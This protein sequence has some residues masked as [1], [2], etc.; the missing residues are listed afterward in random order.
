M[1]VNK[2]ELAGQ[3]GTGKMSRIA[4]E[5]AEALHYFWLKTEDEQVAL[6]KRRLESIRTYCGLEIDRML[7]DET[8]YE[9]YGPDRRE[10]I[11]TM[12]TLSNDDARDI[13]DDMVEGR[14]L[15]AVSDRVVKTI[16]E[17]ADD[18]QVNNLPIHGEY[19]DDASADCLWL[20][21]LG[22]MKH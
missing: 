13:R 21:I 17:M 2:M 19:V 1:A 4:Y 3:F 9:S 16:E 20:Y 5:N 15:G 22:K 14:G 12:N 10:A 6:I 18:K 8:L 11:A 7:R